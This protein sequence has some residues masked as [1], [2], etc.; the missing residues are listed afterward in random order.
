MPRAHHGQQPG[1]RIFIDLSLA[2]TPRGAWKAAPAF[3]AGDTPVKAERPDAHHADF[4]GLGF[5]N[6][7]LG[8]PGVAPARIDFLLG[9]DHIEIIADIRFERSCRWPVGLREPDVNEDKGSI[10]L[11]LWKLNFSKSGIFSEENSPAIVSILSWKKS[12]ACDKAG[13]M[14]NTNGNANA[15]GKNLIVSPRLLKPST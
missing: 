8:L 1:T 6:V 5:V 7:C 14:R 3:R 11:S 9:S 10:G 12:G 4:A 2:E 13:L 15:R